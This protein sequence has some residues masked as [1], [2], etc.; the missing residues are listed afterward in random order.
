MKDEAKQIIED[1]QNSKLLILDA[2]DPNK[3]NT[4]ALLMNEAEFAI[5]RLFNLITN[6]TR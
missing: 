4:Y 6:D 1:Y 5:D 3:I 2:Y